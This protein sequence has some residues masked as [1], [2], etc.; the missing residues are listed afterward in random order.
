M[1]GKKNIPLPRLLL[2]SAL[3]PDGATGPKLSFGT[4]PG[5]PAKKRRRSL[6]I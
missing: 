1:S 4:T 3:G 5:P 6:Y 2:L